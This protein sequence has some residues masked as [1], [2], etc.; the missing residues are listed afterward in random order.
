[1]DKEHII[2]SKITLSIRI[3][4]TLLKKLEE[5]TKLKKTSRSKYII[6]LLEEHFGL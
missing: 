6:L 1:M 3:S 2:N 5:T 4:K